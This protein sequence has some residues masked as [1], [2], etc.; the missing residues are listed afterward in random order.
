MYVCV[1]EHTAVSAG[2][3]TPQQTGTDRTLSATCWCGFCMA[4][5]NAVA[6][7]LA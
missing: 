3:L 6:L 2:T 7:L 1:N 5:R 4:C